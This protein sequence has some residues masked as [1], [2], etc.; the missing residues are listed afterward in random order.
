MKVKTKLLILASLCSL[1]F[2]S[3]VRFSYNY[4]V[5]HVIDGI[6]VNPQNGVD[7]GPATLTSVLNYYGIAVRMDSVATAVR[8]DALEGTLTLDMV[9]YAK[10]RGLD[11]R[12]YRSSLDDLKQCIDAGIPL[13]AMVEMDSANPFD[14]VRK[15]VS[16]YKSPRHYLLV[17]GYSSVHRYVI[18]HTGGELPVRIPF[19]DFESSWESTGRIAIRISQTSQE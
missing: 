13:I 2:F 19:D 17:T 3:C 7:C 5:E 6:P 9:V 18:A 1:A 11:A 15:I 16:D 4:E 8:R 12:L 14:G 10:S